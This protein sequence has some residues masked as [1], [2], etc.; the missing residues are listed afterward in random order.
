MQLSM[1][2]EY[3]LIYISIS[4]C[5]RILHMPKST[6]IYPSVGKYNSICLTLS[7]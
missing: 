3:T 6:K 2:S 1:G 4:N 7:D 5:A